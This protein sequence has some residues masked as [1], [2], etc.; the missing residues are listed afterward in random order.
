MIHQVLAIHRCAIVDS[1]LK[2]LALNGKNQQKSPTGRSCQ[3]LR[4][5][6]SWL[7]Q[8]LPTYS[9]GRSLVIPNTV[10][11]MDF[12]S[13]TINHSQPWSTIPNPS[14]SIATPSLLR[15][16]LFGHGPGG[17]LAK[18]CRKLPAA[19]GAFHQSSI[20]TFQLFIAEHICLDVGMLG[21]KGIKSSKLRYLEL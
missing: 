10:G 14:P 5:R 12:W 15:V 7:H 13:I 20:P 6:Y 17:F 2:K 1:P 19:T 18:S 21:D 3:R 4:H 11:M 9:L 16:A 8:W